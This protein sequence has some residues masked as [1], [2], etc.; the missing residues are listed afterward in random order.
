MQDIARQETTGPHF[1]GD[2]RHLRPWLCLLRLLGRTGCSAGFAVVPQVAVAAVFP[3]YRQRSWNVV[4]VKQIS[5]Q[6]VDYGLRQ[7]YS[8]PIPA[9]P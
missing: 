8:Q 3:G 6:Y 7:N 5:D 4:T 2:R 1:N 9:M